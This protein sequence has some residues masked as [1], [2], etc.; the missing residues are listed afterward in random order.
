[1]HGACADCGAPR[2]P[3]QL[4]LGRWPPCLLQELDPQGKFASEW[5]GWKWSAT[6]NGNPI[7]LAS[8]CTSKG[9]SPSCQCAA[10]TDC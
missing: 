5:D 9:F 4:P 6:L 8:C 2:A 3:S 7:P 1:M 10:R